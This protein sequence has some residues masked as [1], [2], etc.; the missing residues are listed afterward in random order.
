MNSNFPTRK[1]TNKYIKEDG[2]RLLERMC[3][4]GLTLID[5]LILQDCCP[6]I[7]HI[8]DLLDVN[9][10]YYNSLNL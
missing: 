7:R 6:P 9:D 4:D 5:A 1:Q 8:G 3:N 10:P 2:E